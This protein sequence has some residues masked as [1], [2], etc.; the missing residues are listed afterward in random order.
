MYVKSNMAVLA[1]ADEGMSKAVIYGFC[2][3]VRGS[4]CKGETF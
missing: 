1:V 4:Q 3:N 2:I